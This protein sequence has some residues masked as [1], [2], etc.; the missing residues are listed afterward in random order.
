MTPDDPDDA[1]PARRAEL[2]AA[3]AATDDANTRVL[4]VAAALTRLFDEAGMEVTVVGGSAAVVWDADAVATADIDV[5][6]FYDDARLSDVL[7][8]QLGLR[9]SGRFWIDEELGVYV[10]APGWSLEPDGARAVIVPTRVGDVRVIRIEDLVLDRV[11]QWSA[12]GADDRWRQ[13]ARL[14]ES[15]LRDDDLLAARA[16]ELAENAALL[17][18]RMLAAHERGGATVEPELS[19]AVQRVHRRGAEAIRDALHG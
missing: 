11:Q 16:D 7:I 17:A 10:E 6:G 18:V 13:A 9:R 3:L 1:A 15:P 14:M 4:V 8:G 5:V 2:R 19:R 12:T